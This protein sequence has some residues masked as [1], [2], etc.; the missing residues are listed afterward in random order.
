MKKIVFYC[1]DSISNIQKFEYY[2]LDIKAL[3]ELGVNVVICTKYREI[4]KDFDA[5]YIY[6]WSY[7]LF[8]IILA[9]WKRKPAFVSGVFNYRFP[10]WQSGRDYFKRPLWQRLL[11][12][13]AMQLADANLV[14][15]LSD[16]KNCTKAFGLTNAY[17]TP[18]CIGQEYFQ[19]DNNIRSNQ[20]MNIAWSGDSNLKRKGVY[21][22]I[23]AL[24]LVKSSGYQFRL[25]LAGAVGNGAEK[26][27]AMIVKNGLE[28]EVEFIGE[29]SKSHKLQLLKESNIYV[30]PS[31]YEGFGLASAEAMAA[32]LKVISCDVGD[33]K[34]TLGNHAIYVENGNITE[35][36]DEIVKLLDRGVSRTETLAGKSFLKE[37]FSFEKKLDDIRKIVRF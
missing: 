33:V 36:A 21:D 7:A 10:Q 28:N 25:K 19:I 4:P 32:G 15:S 24:T 17:Y 6:W 16:F 29:I 11:M 37:R 31:N 20:L 12:R 1:N 5:I 26:L 14:T 8:P 23:D 27:K 13:S 35:I 2:S 18:C 9:K 30:Q 3:E 22:I 34:N